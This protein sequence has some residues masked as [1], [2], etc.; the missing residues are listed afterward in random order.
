MSPELSEP[1]RSMRAWT[2]VEG[3]VLHWILHH[4]C[5]GSGSQSRLTDDCQ[6]HRRQNPVRYGHGHVQYILKV[7]CCTGYCIISAMGADRGDRRVR[8][9]LLVACQARNLY[10]KKQ[11][12]SSSTCKGLG[13]GPCI[14]QSCKQ[15]GDFTAPCLSVHAGTVQ[16]SAVR[17]DGA[18]EQ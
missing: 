10:A 18:C 15:Q 8:L 11:G 3:V 17:P 14:I 9:G 1:R 16:Y 12:M 13:A 4:I 5:D 6:P 2:S 7:Q